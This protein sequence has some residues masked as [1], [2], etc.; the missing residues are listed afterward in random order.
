MNQS[1]GKSDDMAATTDTSIRW[2]WL[3][4]FALTCVLAFYGTLLQAG[5]PAG[6]SM[7]FYQLEKATPVVSAPGLTC[8]GLTGPCIS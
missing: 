5:H 7:R 6:S 3:T 8:P 4:G 2:Q 1:V